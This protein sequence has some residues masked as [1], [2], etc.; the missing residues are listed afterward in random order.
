MSQKIALIVTS[1]AAPNDVL[2][3]LANECRQQNIHFIVIGDEISP[4]DFSL[5]GCDF[6]SLD[7]Q[8]ELKFEFA[9]QCPTR[10]YARKN[11]GYLI[12]ISQGAN[13]II[14]TDDDNFPTDGFWSQRKCSQ[15]AK[16]LQNQ[17]WANA[18]NYF[19][20]NFIWPRGMALDE[21]RKPLP[22]YETLEEL[23][24]DCPIQQG[25]V[26]ENPDV[27]ALYRLLLKLPVSFEKNRRLILKEKTWCPFNS[28]NTT[29]FA[30]AFGLLYLPAFCSFRMT[31]IWRSFIAQRILWE[32]DWGLLFHEPTMNQER[33]IHNLMKDFEDEIPGYLQNK[34]L[35]DVLENLNLS[36]G[37]EYL[38]DN[39][40]TCYESL[41]DHKIMTVEE[42]ELLNYWI[43]DLNALQH[44]S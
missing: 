43:N 38:L 4:K 30:Q 2:T 26:Q 39:L 23:Q 29:W 42:V 22:D 28:Q 34:K 44:K 27:D 12:A 3:Q 15:Q 6:Y 18:Y 36:A 8:M 35:C 14:E 17:G 1:I 16:I 20:N 32:N 31:D 13:V 25:L 33:N 9:R 10:H 19:T 40:Q 41:A 21:I 5:D 11:I 7:R 37:P 24:A